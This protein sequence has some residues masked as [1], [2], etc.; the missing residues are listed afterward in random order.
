VID[1]GD[2]VIDGSLRT[3][4]ARIGAVLAN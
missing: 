4:L 2:A 1:T 3:K